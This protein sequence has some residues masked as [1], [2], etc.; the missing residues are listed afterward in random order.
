MGTTRRPGSSR[1]SSIRWRQSGPAS[2]G[3]SGRVESSTA[4]SLASTP[5]TTMA[6]STASPSSCCGPARSCCAR[7]WRNQGLPS[8]RKP[9]PC[10]RAST[11][12]GQVCSGACSSLGT[13]PAR[14]QR[15]ET[16]GPRVKWC[17]CR[18][19][20]RV[21]MEQVRR[22]HLIAHLLGAIA[23]G[24]RSDDVVFLGCTALSRTNLTDA[25][26]SE[27]IDSP[28]GV[29]SRGIGVVHRWSSVGATTRPN[30][31]THAAS[32]ITQGRQP[33]TR[34]PREGARSTAAPRRPSEAVGRCRGRGCSDAGSPA[35]T[36]REHRALRGR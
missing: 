12:H 17:S 11:H 1:A 20:F 18:E 34:R 7:P 14:R 25:R 29:A 26:L 36:R 8:P 3:C 22:D 30:T 15:G 27:D 9:R 4:P 23:T 24:L 32:R 21:D 33:P 13:T 35:S 19:R 16:A 2:L 5:P 10:S 31:L 28:G 6:S